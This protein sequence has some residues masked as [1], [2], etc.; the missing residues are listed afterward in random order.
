MPEE[1]VEVVLSYLAAYNAQ[2]LDLALSLCAQDVMTFPAVRYSRGLADTR[3]AGR[4]SKRRGLR[5]R[6]ARSLL[7]RQAISDTVVC[8]YAQ[9]GRTGSE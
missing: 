8:S 1:D 7:G 3:P 9:I 4:F 2:D 6:V 5:G